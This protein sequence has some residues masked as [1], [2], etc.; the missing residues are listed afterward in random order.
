MN[1]SRGCELCPLWLYDFF[2]PYI[3]YVSTKWDEP[4]LIFHMIYIE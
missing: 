2:E 1:I 4:R 3:K